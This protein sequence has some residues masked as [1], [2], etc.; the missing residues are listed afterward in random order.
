MFRVMAEEF[1]EEKRYEFESL[2]NGGQYN[3]KQKTYAF[4]L[5]RESGIRTAAR[6]LKIPRRT[7]M[8]C[9][10]LVYCRRLIYRI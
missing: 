5:I 2:G 1:N 4:E 3:D 7:L 9:G 8:G 10:E 6:I